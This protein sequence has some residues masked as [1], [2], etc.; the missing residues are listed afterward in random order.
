LADSGAA[1]STHMRLSAQGTLTDVLL[2]R[3]HTTRIV[4]VNTMLLGLAA[5]LIGTFAYLRKRALM[6]DALSHATLPGVAG[7]YLLTGSKS[8]LPLISGAAITGVLG[9]LSVIGISRYSRLK[10]DAA[11]G[12]VLSVFFGVGLTLVGV[13]QYSATGNAAGL[14]GFIYGKPASL[15]LQ[16][17]RLIQFATVAIIAVT[18]LLYKE[19]RSVCFDPGFAAS[20]GWPV[21][22]IDVLMM[23]LVV[24][25][26]VIGLQAVGLILIIALLIVPAA[27]ARFWT[28]DLAAMLLSASL[29]GCLSGYVGSSIS[30]LV[31][32]LPTGGIIVIVAG[33][34][35]AISMMLAPKRGILS[36][37]LRRR[38]LRVRIGLQN[39]LRAL[40]E[41]E[42]T[43]GQG[44]S[45]QF[46]EILGKRSWS[47]TH[48]WRLIG[49][50]ERRGLVA[51][52]PSH[53]IALTPAGRIDAR[54]ILRNHR[55]WEI[56]LIQHADI[57]PSHVDRDADELEHV[58]PRELVDELET[59]LAQRATIPPSPHGEG[60]EV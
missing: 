19:F 18:L 45:P 24:L 51:R 14:Q 46:V 22:L 4:V 47:G 12:I 56:Y 32:R 30:A 31:P 58:L 25:V 40:A 50:A 57:A 15:T 28:D 38:T 54:R 59:S 6:G 60:S 27:A 1:N 16:D 26:T 21:G 13:A 41:F 29:F 34:I 2:L 3:R 20:Q 44:A 49:K 48:L 53:R 5:G 23:S 55:L 10:E 11:I 52:L 43:K 17:A 35:F 42:E 33:C 36:A 37:V 39:L 9:V 7:A 8:L